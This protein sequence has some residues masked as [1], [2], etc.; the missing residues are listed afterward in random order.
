[1]EAPVAAALGRLDGIN[2]FDP[3]W[4]DPEYDVWYRLL[5]CGLRLPASTGSDWFVCS[6]NRVY[7]ETAESFSYE[8]WLAG[9]R[10]GRTFI[11]D[12]P[13][14]RLSVARHHPNNAVLDL[15]PTTRSASVVVEWE[16]AQPIDRLEIVRDGVVAAFM[17]N[18]DQATRGRFET[19]L[20]VAEAGWLA[21]RCWGRRRTSYGHALWAHTSPVYMRDR[22]ERSVVRAAADSFLEHIDRATTWISTRA[23]FE[24]AAQRDRVIQL[25][26]EG[27]VEFERLTRA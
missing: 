15:A 25:Y 10:D 14:L 23:R 7:V 16:S 13:I 20:D 19:T 5:N 11:T 22:P 17:E 21:A 2:L 12:G 4:K 27:R 9:L 24:N 3:Y 6:S 1:M 8:S 26:A 18:P